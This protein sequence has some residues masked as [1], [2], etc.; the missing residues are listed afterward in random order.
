MEKG[1]R[2][3]VRTRMDKGKECLFTPSNRV[4]LARN[5]FSGFRLEDRHDDSNTR[6]FIEEKGHTPRRPRER[7]DGQ[8]KNFGKG[9][10]ESKH[11]SVEDKL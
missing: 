10:H 2:N 9:D 1:A 8:A 4:E 3:K 6:D 11:L 5:Y 7:L